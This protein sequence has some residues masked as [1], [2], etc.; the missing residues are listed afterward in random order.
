MELSS[1]SKPEN[2]N[3]SPYADLGY[4]YL[5]ELVNL[6]EFVPAFVGL[7]IFK[8]GFAKECYSGGFNGVQSRIINTLADMERSFSLE[9]GSLIGRLH[10]A[11]LGTFDE[12]LS[13]EQ[14]FHS[15]YKPFRLTGLFKDLKT[16]GED[17]VGGSSEFSNMTKKQ[18]AARFANSWRKSNTAKG[19]EI[20]N[21]K[22]KHGIHGCPEPMGKNEEPSQISLDN[23]ITNMVK[24]AYNL[25]GD[26]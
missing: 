26:V 8:D 13:A 21:H 12:T 15:R 19:L 16:R 11:K 24:S 9:R 7:S 25:K 4:N 23:D 5:W 2:S 6:G 20:V 17:A 1:N 3:G 10:F 18:A 14:F 22:R